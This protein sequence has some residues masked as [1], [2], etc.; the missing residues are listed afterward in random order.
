MAFQTLREPKK[1]TVGQVYD[2]PI[3]DLLSLKGRELYRS[4]VEKNGKKVKVDDILETVS[5]IV[6]ETFTY[7]FEL[8]IKMGVHD[9][10]DM[11]N[12]LMDKDAGAP[13]L[14]GVCRHGVQLAKYLLG[15]LGIEAEYVK[16]YIGATCAEDIDF[17]GPKHAIVATRIPETEKY[18][19][20]NAFSSKIET[21]VVRT[22][23]ELSGVGLLNDVTIN[24]RT[25]LGDCN[26]EALISYEERT[27]PVYKATDGSH[28]VIGVPGG[29]LSYGSKPLEIEI[30][31]PL[32]LKKY[33][34]R[35]VTL[36]NR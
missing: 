26:H 3:P 15:S 25:M 29:E 2:V 24:N 20:M 34:L 6:R 31:K 8:T 33:Y 14:K 9:E 12:F 16:T 32:N 28:Y 4:L 7:D 22:E 11:I 10:E 1:Q 27:L 18:R 23:E 21:R 5:E 36:L 35:E 13:T 19:L 17:D 30:L